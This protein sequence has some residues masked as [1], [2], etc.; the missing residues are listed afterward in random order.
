M[1]ILA[2]SDTISIATTSEWDCEVQAASDAVDSLSYAMNLCEDLEFEPEN[3]RKVQID[4]Q[5]GLDWY[6]STKINTKSRHFQIKY[7]T[8]GLANLK[9]VTGKDNDSDINTK[10]LGIKKT[11]DLT[12]NILGHHLVLRQ[13]IRGII[14]LDDND[15]SCV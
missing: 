7:Y 10:V 5:S 2:S 6:N 1:A 12:R 4:S 9:V 14:E 15:V 3:N 8:Q 11:R 13:G